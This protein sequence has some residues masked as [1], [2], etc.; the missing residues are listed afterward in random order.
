MVA[1]YDVLGL[2][3]IVPFVILWI[4]KGLD[5][6][7]IVITAVICLLVAG[8]AGIWS[9]TVANGAAIVAYYCLAAGA[10]MMLIEPVILK[11]PIVRDQRAAGKSSFKPWLERMLLELKAR[12]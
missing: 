9:S 11:I 12:R 8:A 1:V 3:I 5:S 4:W 2:A 7:L 10:A 6:R